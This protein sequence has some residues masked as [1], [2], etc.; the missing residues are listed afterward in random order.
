MRIILFLIYLVPLLIV[1]LAI[2]ALVC[3]FTFAF[4]RD[5][6]AVH[7]ISHIMS[8][9]ITY[10][11][12]LWRMKTCGMEN[13]VRGKSYVVTVNHH[14]MIDIPV[15]YSL[16]LFFKW[17][18][19]REVLKMP[20]FGWVL[21]LRGDIAIERGGVASTMKLFKRTKELTS[22]GCSVIIF[23][24]GTRSKSGAVGR[25]KDGAFIMAK[26]NDV[27]ILPVVINYTLRGRRLFGKTIKIPCRIELK[28]LKPVDIETV[29]TKS[30][31][32]LRD[33]VRDIMVGEH[34]ASHPGLYTQG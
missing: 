11:S 10:L 28:A 3:L 25:F 12:V 19:K 2:I 4:D 6:R 1:E 24:E 14:S 18:S 13:I 16:P 34:K 17:V 22:R 27:E 32:E 30:A 20:L 5:R 9:T 29:R 15:C 7:G 8:G 26:D 23:P 33:M 21:R 31:G